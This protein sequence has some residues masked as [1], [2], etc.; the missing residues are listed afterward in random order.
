MANAQTVQITTRGIQ[1][2]LKK[3]G[4]F[5]SIAEY[6][7]NGFDAKADTVE[8][9]LGIATLNSIDKISIKDNG[10]G[11]NRKQL[12]IKFKPF[13]QSEKIYDPK[14]KHSDIHGKNGVGRLTFFTFCSS[15]KW[16][17]T[18]AEDGKSFNYNIDVDSI[19]LEKYVESEEEETNKNSG[20][21]V[22]FYG[23]DCK[24][25]SLDT[26]KTFLANEFCWYLELKKKLNYKILINDIEL[27]YSSNVKMRKS[28]SFL[29]EPSGLIFDVD[30]VLWNKRLSDYSKYYYIDLE[31][32]EIAKENTTLNNKGDKFY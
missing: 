9:S 26:I 3:F 8:V 6:I 18:Y 25:F 1:N 29:Y 24:D 12:D 14:D 4:P 28:A 22:T 19:S 15:V 13:F 27:D 32:E 31:G 23:V 16:N 17:T 7:W 21:L 20:T 30:V 2:S 10:H 11:I 5:E